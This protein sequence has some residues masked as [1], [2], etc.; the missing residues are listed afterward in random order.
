MR[1]PR[2]LHHLWYHILEVGTWPLE[3]ADGGLRCTTCG[4]TIITLCR[5]KR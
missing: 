5:R 1:L 3:D 2:P 4:K